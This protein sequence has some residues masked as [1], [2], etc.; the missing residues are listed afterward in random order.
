MRKKTALKKN[1]Y[2][3]DYIMG[4]KVI[5]STRLPAVEEKRAMLTAKLKNLIMILLAKV[6]AQNNES[7][8]KEVLSGII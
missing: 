1:P 3:I 7:S 2:I 6:K 4:K 5:R 8:F